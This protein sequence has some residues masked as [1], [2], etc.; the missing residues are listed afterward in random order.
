M[1]ETALPILL[2]GVLLGFLVLN[3]HP[4]AI[5][6]G[7]CGSMFLPEHTV[8]NIIAGLS[9]KP[10]LSEVALDVVL[11]ALAYYGAYVLRWDAD[12]PPEQVALFAHTLPIVIV[13]QMLSFLMWGVYRSLW[14]YVGFD[15]LLVMAKAVLTGVALSGLAILAIHGWQGPSR[16]VLILF[17][18]L[19]FTFVGG[20][21]LSFRLLHEWIMGQAN[22]RPEAIPILIY[23]AGNGGELL[24]REIH[25]HANHLYV[26]IG[27]IDD[28]ARK[29]GRLLHGYRIFGPCDLPQLI[30]RHRVRE[31]L[32]SSAKIPDQ[33]LEDLHHLGVAWKRIRFHIE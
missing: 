9:Y 10:R 7:D 31:V 25:N 8:I 4:A 33:I 24:I 14:R 30:D 21:R 2:G 12:L 3:V 6:R 32:I 27:F 18:L 17:T 16:A 29:V 15:D 19:L 11:T 5:F 13:V 1:V 20:S 26:P 23:G 28:D 22:C